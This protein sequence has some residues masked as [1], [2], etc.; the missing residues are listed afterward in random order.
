MLQIKTLVFNIFQENT[1]IVTNDG[2]R[3]V[4]IDPGFY[5]EDEKREFFDTVEKLNLTIDAVLL[6]HAHLDHVYG[7]KAV[8]SRTG[9]RVYL[10]PKDREVMNKD[11]KLYEMLGINNADQTFLSID[12]KDGDVFE[13]AGIE[14]H[15]I[16][17]PG[18]TPGGVC[19]HIPS[20]NVLFTGDT[21]FSGTIGRTD[22]SYSDY[23]REIV[24]IMEKIIVLDSDTEIFPGH[25][26]C[27]NIGHERTHN[28]MLEPFN[29]PE[30]D[31]DPDLPGIRI[32]R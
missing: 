24:S 6:T 13:E 23:D 10:N 21:L 26:P 20:K 28:P 2:S 1:Y 15:V 27:S 4:I 25:G 16:E 8:Q 3:C 19:F 9:C 22:F 12:I 18:H 30:E 17:T 11:T 5:H 31:I 32:T 29:E 14:F 7:T